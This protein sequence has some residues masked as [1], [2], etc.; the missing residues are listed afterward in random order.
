M[1]HAYRM[2]TALMQ[3]C[4]ST[5]MMVSVLFLFASPLMTNPGVRSIASLHHLHRVPPL[6]LSLSSHFPSLAKPGVRLVSSPPSLHTTLA[7]P[8][9]SHQRYCALNQRILAP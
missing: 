2:D 8:S 6:L 5:W 3:P 7:S 9:C 1:Q 4:T